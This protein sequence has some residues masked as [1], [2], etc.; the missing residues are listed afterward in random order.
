MDKVVQDIPDTVYSFL[1]RKKNEE[2]EER[3]KGLLSIKAP[4]VII[5]KLK[6]DL[7]NYEKAM[8]RIGHIDEFRELEVKDYKIK[9]GK[10]GKTFVELYTKEGTIYYFPHAK[11]GPFLSK[12]EQ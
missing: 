6:K 9:K 5:E 7:E 4:Q 12:K 10:G 2:A 8:D 1:Y 3:L 11:F